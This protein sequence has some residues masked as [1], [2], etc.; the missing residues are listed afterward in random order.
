MQGNALNCRIKAKKSKRPG[1]PFYK[2]GNLLQR[3]FN[4]NC[5]IEVLVTDITYLPFGNTMLN[6]S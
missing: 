6:L 5:P 1:N 2:T 3:N 4:A